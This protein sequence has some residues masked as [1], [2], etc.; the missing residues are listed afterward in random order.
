MSALLTIGE[1]S[2]AT[3]LTVKTLRFYHEKSILIPARVD[4]GT[5]Y[6]FYSVEQT[7]QA[8]VI[9]ALKELQFSIQQITQIVTDVTDETDLLDY[10]ENKQSDIQSRMQR[11]RQTVQSIKSIVT[12]IRETRTLMTTSTTTFETKTIEPILVAAYNMNAPYKDCGTGFKKIGKAFG[13]HMNGKG[14]L[15]CHDDEYKEIANYDVCFP[16]RKGESK[17]DIEVRELPQI[18]C[19]TLIHYGPY[20]TISES[21]AKMLAYLKEHD[22]KIAGPSREVY[23]KGPGMILKGNPKNYVTELQFPIAD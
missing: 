20:D 8:R 7:E 2:R 16:I 13:R 9:K 11:D 15:L 10:L 5:G 19:V 23:L 18:R 4:V 12:D 22:L 14:M 17:G 6:R 1:F 3:G 21:Y